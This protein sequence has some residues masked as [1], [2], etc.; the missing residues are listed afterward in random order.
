ML[1]KCR[2]R[3][4]FIRCLIYTVLTRVWFVEYDCL[5]K[6]YLSCLLENAKLYLH[7]FYSCVS[8]VFHLLSLLS[9]NWRTSEI[10]SLVK[11]F[12][13]SSVG[14]HDDV[15]TPDVTRHSQPND[16]V[17]DHLKPL[18]FR[19]NCPFNLKKSRPPETWWCHWP[20]NDRWFHF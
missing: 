4:L 16:K 1:L 11:S 20:I 6:I 18:I 8:K 14:R 10:L 19:S 13:L 17:L 15:K 12:L 9:I 3:F 5:L 7:W 2:T